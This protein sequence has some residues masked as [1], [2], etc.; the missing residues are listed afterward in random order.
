MVIDVRDYDNGAP[1]KDDSRRSYAENGRKQ[2]FIVC[3][4]SSSVEDTTCFDAVDGLAL[5]WMGKEKNI[6]VIYHM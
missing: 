5:I 6:V 3:F 4:L 2:N 1:S